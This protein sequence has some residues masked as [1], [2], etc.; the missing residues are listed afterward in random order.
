MTL[1]EKPGGRGA[2]ARLR[3]VGDWVMVDYPSTQLFGISGTFKKTPAQVL[4]AYPRF[5][6]CRTPGGQMVCQPIDDA[7]RA[8]RQEV[9]GT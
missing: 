4:R 3:A 9:A 6:L 5:Y 1:E 8:R 7:R 2:A